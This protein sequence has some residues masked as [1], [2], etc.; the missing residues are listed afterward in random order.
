MIGMKKR[1][2]Y[3]GWGIL[4]L[5]VSLYGFISV[6]GQPCYILGDID[7]CPQE[8]I[9]LGSIALVILFTPIFV[10]FVNLI[11]WLFYKKDKSTSEKMRV[12]I[13]T[14]VSLAFIAFVLLSVSRSL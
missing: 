2:W 12:V 9:F 6:S 14:L 8:K 1:S 3:I 4:I 10:L 7:S 11:D 13:G 5:A